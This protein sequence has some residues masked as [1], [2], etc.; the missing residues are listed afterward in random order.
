MVLWY[1]S[2]DPEAMKKVLKEIE[3]IFPAEGKGVKMET[4]N[5]ME[6]LHAVIKETLR[7]ASPAVMLFTRK[8]EEDIELEDVLIKKGMLTNVC[9]I[10]NQFN[11]KYYEN[12]EEFR[13]ERWFED[14]AKQN[15]PFVF[16]PFSGG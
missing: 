13:P 7:L 12:P 15:D 16:I 5:K 10:A 4:L 8:I 9:M 3:E 2:K 11:P 6:Y 1:L 14:Q